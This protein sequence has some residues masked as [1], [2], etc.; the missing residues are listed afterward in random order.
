MLS[1]QARTAE[2]A[3]GT[4]AAEQACPKYHDGCVPLATFDCRTITRSSFIHRVC[5]KEAKRYM[6]IWFKDKQET[7]REPPY[8]YCDIGP[9]IMEEF[10]AAPSMGRYYNANIKGTAAKRGPFDCRD[11]LVPDWPPTPD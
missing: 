3:S 1:C 10:L 9:Q 11:H 2:H 7:V 6:I 5:Y 4:T 8:H